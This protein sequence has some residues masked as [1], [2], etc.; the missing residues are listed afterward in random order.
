MRNTGLELTQTDEIWIRRGRRV[1]PGDRHRKLSGRP[2]AQSLERCLISPSCVMFTRSF[3]ER[4]GP[5]DET[6]PACEDYDLWLRAL[7]YYEAG[8]LQEKL[9]VKDG[10][11]ED[12]LSGKIVG[13]DLYRIYALLKLIRQP[14]L[15]PDERELV[16]AALHR[17][18]GVYVRG[19]LKHDKPEE[20]Q[21]IM[22]LL[23]AVPGHSSVLA[24]R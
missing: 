19:C 6:L 7:R 1:N 16:L 17:K 15:K 22:A 3:R 23:E 10:G 9:V 4:I 8:F 14:D 24:P 2:F 13:L 5:F 20:A 18:A 12:Q 11:R 21:R